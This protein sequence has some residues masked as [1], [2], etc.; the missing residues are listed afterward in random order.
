MLTDDDAVGQIVYLLE[1]IAQKHGEH[2]T[3]KQG[4]FPAVRHI[5]YEGCHTMTSFLK[6]FKKSHCV[7]K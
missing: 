3:Q 7:S 1:Q 6:E 5:F 4:C 2:E